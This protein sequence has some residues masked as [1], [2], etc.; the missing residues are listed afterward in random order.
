M[1][2]H[3][4]GNANHLIG[5]IPRPSNFRPNPPYFQSNPPIANRVIQTKSNQF[6]PSSFFSLKALKPS[7]YPNQT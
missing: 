2:K 7:H 6:K 1:P 5:I 4:P 3:C